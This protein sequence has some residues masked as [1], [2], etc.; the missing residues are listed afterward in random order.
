MVARSLVVGRVAEALAAGNRGIQSRLAEHLGVAVQTVNKW[1]RRQTVP[2]PGSFG[3]IEAFFGWPPGTL[4]ALHLLDV[5]ASSGDPRLDRVEVARADLVVLK[6][7]TFTGTWDQLQAI[8]R[9]IGAM[10]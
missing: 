4:L 7:I 8:G 9:L 10:S 6:E 1:S 3:A 2:Q 5:G